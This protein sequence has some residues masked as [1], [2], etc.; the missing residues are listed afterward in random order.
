MALCKK[1]IVPLYLT[2]MI[3]FM[4][5]IYLVVLLCFITL[6]SNSQTLE[7]ILP[8]I[9]RAV[10]TVY[11]HD[12]YGS[13]FSQGSGFFITSQGVGITNFHVLEGA[14]GGHIED[15]DGNNYEI[16]KVIDYN[17]NYDLV[18]FKVKDIKS[19]AFLVLASSNPKQGTSI[20]NYSTPVGFEN[21][22]STGVVS[23][24][25]NMAG[26]ESVIQITT[27]ISH[28]SSG[29]PVMNFSKQVI[30]VATFGVEAGQSLN[31]AV[32]AQ[33]INKL[34]R[35]LNIPVSDI[36]RN[37]LETKLV[38]T[39]YSLG[40]SGEYFQ[41]INLLSQE[42][43]HNPKNH[44]ALYHRGVFKCRS[45]LDYNSGLDD[46]SRACNLVQ[47]SNY[48]YLM[49][50]ATFLKD[51]I[52]LQNDSK[53]TV[54]S[55]IV[56]HTINVLQAASQLDP[57][58]SDP[59]SYL[60]YIIYLFNKNNPQKL[61]HAL[62]AINY[63][64]Q[65]SPTP[66]ILVIRAQIESKLNNYA[67]AIL[68]C[69]YAI[70]IDPTYYRAYFIRGDIKVFDIRSFNDGL[71]DIEKALV[72]IP[73]SKIYEKADIIALRGSARAS[74]ALVELGYDATMLVSQALADYDEAY[75]LVPFPIYKQR[76]KE[77]SDEINNYIKIHKQFP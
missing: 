7:N 23:S 3:I 38:K 69:D 49:H 32:S 14:M 36:V 27:P 58:R 17:P 75:K 68:D 15:A 20:F 34:T 60:A 41:A 2:Y 59:Y 19:S 63:A 50:Y 29:S 62:Q 8:Q 66:E 22:A 52:V 70:N 40:G 43:M 25:R 5:R 57:S 33:Q 76:A 67:A 73:D 6:N 64:I 21:T 53:Q 18:K 11:A 48:T 26:Y 28:G 37:P 55:D 1:I 61:N 4:N 74:K 30:G 42:L 9:K 35:Q 24:L 13:P 65:L 71:L 12:E 47:N 44:L 56:E 10:F 46:L 45:G 51:L 77:L 16:E 39:A 31:F 72:L 54:S